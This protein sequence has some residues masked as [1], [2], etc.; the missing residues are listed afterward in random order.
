MSTYWKH[1][2]P[3]TLPGLRVEVKDG[4]VEKAIRILNKKV[5]A[6]GLLKEL[7]DREQFTKPS[8]KRRMA[9]KAA[10]KRHQKEL[11]E[12]KVRKAEF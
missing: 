6:S 4:N 1:G 12:A 2:A 10:V 11:S 7:R 3:V 5:Q 9:R 8:V